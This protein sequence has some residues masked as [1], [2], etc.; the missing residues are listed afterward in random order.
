MSARR[1]IRFRRFT[2]Y[3]R[4]LHLITSD[5]NCNYLFRFNVY[6]LQNSNAFPSRIMRL[7]FLQNAFCLNVLRVNKTSDFINFLHSFNLNNRITIICMAFTRRI[8]SNFAT[9]ISNGF[10]GI[11]KI[12]ARMN[13]RSKFM[14]ALHRRRNLYRNRSRFTNDLLL[15][16]ENNRQNNKDFLRQA[17]DSITSNGHDY[18]ATLRRF[19]NFYLY[20][21]P[22]HRFNFRFRYF[23]IDIQGRRCNNGAMKYFNL[24]YVCLTFTLCGRASN[25]KLCATYEG[26]EFRFL[27]R[28]Q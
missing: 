23:T 21:R 20:L 10:K 13:C 16:N 17:N 2:N 8:K 22:I 5:G 15:R 24:R 1:A 27:P 18:F 3:D 12:N 14:R 28:C 4:D 6:R 26:N 25:C 11:S 9:N 19:P 7:S